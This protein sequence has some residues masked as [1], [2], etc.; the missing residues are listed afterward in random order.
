MLDLL[1]RSKKALKATP[2]VIDHKIDFN[3]LIEDKEPKTLQQIYQIV[4]QFPFRV[5]K[6]NNRFAWGKKRLPKGTVLIC[7]RDGLT[8]YICW[9]RNDLRHSDVD[10][11]VKAWVMW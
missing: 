9:D 6:V 1:F 2:P 11:N 3:K 7:K 5:K 4:G 8:G 10:V